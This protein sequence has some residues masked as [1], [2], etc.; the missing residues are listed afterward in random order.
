MKS[1]TKEDVESLIR[2]LEGYKGIKDRYSEKGPL[3]GDCKYAVLIDFLVEHYEKGSFDFG[4]T[5]P[6]SVGCQVVTW[7]LK[8]QF[9]DFLFGLDMPDEDLPL[10]ITDKTCYQYPI[11]TWRLSHAKRWGRCL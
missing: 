3:Y 11:A 5:I 4:L 1:Y 2:H 8:E 6:E 10:Y 9:P 7:E